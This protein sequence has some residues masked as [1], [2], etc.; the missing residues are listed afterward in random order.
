MTRDVVAAATIHSTQD[1]KHSRIVS[2]KAR[3]LHRD[4]S[5]KALVERDVAPRHVGLQLEELSSGE[6]AGVRRTVTFGV[7]KSDPPSARSHAP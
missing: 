5:E 6:D 2:E 7:L 1:L 3:G 4:S